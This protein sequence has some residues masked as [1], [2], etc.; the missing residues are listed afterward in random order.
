MATKESSDHEQEGDPGYLDFEPTLFP[1]AR[2]IELDALV[3]W[4]EQQMG[5][6][7]AVLEG[8]LEVRPLK[9]K[10]GF[11]AF[12]KTQDGLFY[13]EGLTVWSA[14]CAALQSSETRT[15]TTLKPPPQLDLIVEKK[16]EVPA[17]VREVV[18]A[19]EAVKKVEACGAS[20]CKRP[21][22]V[23]GF[24]K[25]HLSLASVSGARR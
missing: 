5:V 1:G 2:L 24:C 10:P 11:R 14:T 8:G 17:R 12:L 22:L 13:G 4:N 16:Q 3:E 6:D 9:K 20:L 21:P 25:R 7:A 18:T 19:I 15:R 23:G